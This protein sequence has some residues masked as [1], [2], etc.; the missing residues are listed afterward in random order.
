MLE[1]SPAT[2]VSAPGTAARASFARVSLRAWRTTRWPAGTMS[3]A[4]I[5][6]RPSAAPVTKIRAIARDLSRSRRPKRAWHGTGNVTAVSNLGQERSMASATTSRLPQLL[7]QYRKHSGG[8]A[9][10]IFR[11]RPGDRDKR[12]GFW[13]LIKIGQ[14]LDLIFILF[15]NIRLKRVI[16]LRGRDPGIGVR[17]L[18]PGRSNFSSFI[19]IAQNFLAPT[20]VVRDLIRSDI[21]HLI[22]IGPTLGPVGSHCDKGPFGNGSVS[23]F[24]RANVRQRQHIVGILSHF[25]MNVKN[26]KR[27]QHFFHIDLILRPQSLVKM[28]WRIDMC[29]PLTDMAVLFCPESILVVVK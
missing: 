22:H 2:A 27:H 8:K 17:C 9:R 15:Q 1:R 19:E 6:P 4:A 26:H 14:Q 13:H 12:P 11:L 28:G 29:P 25:G 24:P 10:A 20:W 23:G 5:R 16:I 21:L 7:R 3:L 18:M